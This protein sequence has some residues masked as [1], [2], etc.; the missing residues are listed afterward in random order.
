MTNQPAPEHTLIE[1]TFLRTLGKRI[2]I[3]RLT[4]ELSQEQLAE[5]AGMS[6]N[7]VSSIEHGKH[8][9]DIVRLFRISTVLGVPLA[10]LLPPAA[11]ASDQRRTA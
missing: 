3:Q 2:R 9:V 4:A 7:F 1:W 8:G 11:P 5:R 6:R 10:E